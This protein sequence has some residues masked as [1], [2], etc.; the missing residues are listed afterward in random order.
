MSAIVMTKFLKKNVGR[1]GIK[2]SPEGRAEDGRKRRSSRFPDS[3]IHDER[4]LRLELRCRCRGVREDHGRAGPQS[5]AE[6]L[7]VSVEIQIEM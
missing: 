2:M 7:M 4:S 1:K 5:I 3:L 6:D